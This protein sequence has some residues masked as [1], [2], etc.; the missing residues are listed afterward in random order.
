MMRES[1]WFR[2]RDKNQSAC[3]PWAKSRAYC[4]ASRASSHSRSDNRLTKCRSS[5]RT[6][7]PWAGRAASR[8]SARRA[9]VRATSN[10]AA[11]RGCARGRPAIEPQS[12]G[13]QRRQF[14]IEHEHVCR[15]QAGEFRGG[16]PRR[17]LLGAGDFAHQR[18][19]KTLRPGQGGAE[20]RAA[21]VRPEQRLGGAE[22]DVEF[23]ECPDR[24]DLRVI[25]RHA[26][27]V[28]QAGGAV[29]ARAG[30]DGARHGASI[31]RAQAIRRAASCARRQ[32]SAAL[33]TCAWVIAFSVRLRQSR[34]N[35]PK[36]RK[37][38]WPVT[39]R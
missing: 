26:L 33:N 34:I 15:T 13:L 1:E 30:G 10:A 23:I 18:D 4:S 36:K 20:F 25:L 2:G 29:V 9:A 6:V 16:I 3:I 38:T 32:S 12:A 11:E 17:V 35:S 22:G 19:Q 21:R 14:A 5:G 28:K 8:R 7:R 31:I 27:P 37:P 24:F 39:L